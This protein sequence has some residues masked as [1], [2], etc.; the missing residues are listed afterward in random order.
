MDSKLPRI[1]DKPVTTC[2]SVFLFFSPRIFP[3]H[4][5]ML[6]PREARAQRRLVVC[7]VVWENGLEM[8]M[9]MKRVR[10]KQEREAAGEEK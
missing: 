2:L 10:E 4:D 8:E 5:P 6:R 3:Y 9:E 7:A 1:F